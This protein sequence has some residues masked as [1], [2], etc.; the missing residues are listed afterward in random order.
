MSTASRLLR[1]WL[2]CDRSG[3]LPQRAPPITGT[4]LSARVDAQRKSL[5]ELEPAHVPSSPIS[6]NLQEIQAANSSLQLALNS[7]NG[8]T[9]EPVSRVPSYSDS[10]KKA[11][12]PELVGLPHRDL[13]KMNDRSKHDAKL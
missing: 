4:C 5:R 7:H 2:W 1:R 12:S 6:F 11:S 13:I 3:S 10:S 9:D 8:A